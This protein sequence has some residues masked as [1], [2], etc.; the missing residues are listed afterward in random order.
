MK[1]FAITPDGLRPRDL[2]DRLE[3][4]EAKK[5]SFLYLRTPALHGSLDL[6][7]PEVTRG[8]M[9]PLLP[10]RAWKNPFD[11]PV[12]IHF[13]SSNIDLLSNRLLSSGCITTASSHSFEEASGLLDRGVDHV[14]VSPV[15]PPLSKPG[16]GARQ[17]RLFPRSRLRELAQR[18]GERVVALGGMQP[19]NIQELKKEL[20]ADFSVAGVTLFFGEQEP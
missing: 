18:H 10:A 11:F 14:F 17:A 2:L 1:F 9:I 3:A 15:F 12:G 5:I 20:G 19:G 16:E 13:K 6:L 8:G 7:L 4:L